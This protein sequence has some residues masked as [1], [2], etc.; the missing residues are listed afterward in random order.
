MTKRLLSLLLAVQAILALDTSRWKVQ[1]AIQVPE[2]SANIA[3]VKLTREVYVQS[4][5][6]LGDL[7]VARGNEE[8]PYLMDARRGAVE[9]REIAPPVINQS[10]AQGRGLQLTLDLGSHF[11]HSRIRVSTAQTNFKQKVR[12]ETGD[13][14]R[15]WS[16]ARQDGYIFDFSQGDRHMALLTVDY[17]ASTMHYVRVTVYGW[18]KTDAVRQVWAAY[19][20]EIPAERDVMDSV[21]PER[22]EDPETKSSLLLIDLKQAGVPYDR[23]RLESEPVHYYRAAELETSKDGKDWRFA[24]TGTIFQTASEPSTGLTFGERH[25]RYLR[26]RIFNGDDKPIPVKRVVIEATVR[27]LKFFLAAGAGP[28]YLLTGNPDAKAP[29]YDLAAVLARE[30]PQPEVHATLLAPADNP[31]YRPPPPPVKPWSERYPQL[32]YGTLAV[33][34]LVMGYVTVRFLL[35][36]KSASG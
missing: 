10:V 3:V 27:L 1:S 12:I 24:T 29:F 35:K 36:V 33:A 21:V 14:G 23:V 25:E 16:I 15:S 34:I 22:S 9:F 4:R 8:I 18:M 17:P 2:R 28:F 26:L 11:K 30:A 6:D 7:R 31:G 13:D 20:N 5:T 19:R 32:L